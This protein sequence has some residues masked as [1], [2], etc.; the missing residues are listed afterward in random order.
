MKNMLK[1]KRGITLIALIVTIIVLLILAGI[2]ITTL[3]GENGLINKAAGTTEKQ[4]KAQALE[5]VKLAVESIKIDKISDGQ[6]VTLD[7]FTEISKNGSLNLLENELYNNDNNVNAR[8]DNINGENV[9]AIYYKN[10][11]FILTGDLSIEEFTSSVAI[12]PNITGNTI[13]SLTISCSI[14]EEDSDIDLSKVTEIYY[15]CDNGVSWRNSSKQTQFEYDGLVANTNY[16]IKVKAIINGKDVISNSI[17]GR[18]ATTSAYIENMPTDFFTTSDEG[19]TITG[20][21][22]AYLSNGNIVYDGFDGTLV[23]PSVWK[24]VSVTGIGDSAFK[25]R[26]NINKLYIE[27]GIKNIG[28]GSFTNCSALNEVILPTTLE[29]I[30]KSNSTASFYGCSNILKVTIPQLIINDEAGYTIKEIFTNGY[31][32]I[33]NVNYNGEITYIGK[34]AF[35]GCKALTSIDIPSTVTEIRYRAYY[36]CIAASEITIPEKVKTIGEGA[37]YNCTSI[38]DLTIKNE[39]EEIGNAAF[40][41]CKALINL[42]IAEGVKKLRN[43]GFFWLYGIN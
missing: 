3:S 33:T 5:E 11:E 30:Y 28:N 4:K 31:E 12:I 18:T 37:F 6:T 39:V 36:N 2:T 9:L 13:T 22:S 20:I 41:G 43:I 10:Y 8:I 24:N 42:N 38:T 1:N 7:S 16:N 25:L 14:K 27:E 29:T 40:S 34:N 32:K 19:A 23:I 26:K 35:N 21:N 15:S 17:T